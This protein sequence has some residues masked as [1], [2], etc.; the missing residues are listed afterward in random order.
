MQYLLHEVY[1]S[2][3]VLYAEQGENAVHLIELCVDVEHHQMQTAITV[4]VL[5][6][7][8]LIFSFSDVAAW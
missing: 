4:L 6:T 1:N 8:F 2:Q 5:S 3:D 7:P